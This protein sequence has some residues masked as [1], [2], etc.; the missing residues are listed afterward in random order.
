MTPAEYQDLLRT[1]EVKRYDLMSKLIQRKDAELLHAQLG[2]M[3]EAGEFADIIKKY[4]IYGKEIDKTNLIEELGDL[5]WYIGLAISA[6]GSTWG[7]VFEANINK[8][9]ARYPEQFTEHHALNRDLEVERKVLD[10][11][12]GNARRDSRA[13]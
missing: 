12:T 4:L 11:S 8:L 5:T 1:T 6:I 2:I 7:Q 9:A 13:Y 10:E 3:T